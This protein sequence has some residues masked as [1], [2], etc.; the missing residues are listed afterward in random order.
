[1]MGHTPLS[2]CTGVRGLKQRDIPTQNMQQC[3]LVHRGPWKK[4]WKLIGQSRRER[5]PRLI[6]QSDT[7]SRQR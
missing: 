6:G 2:P 4:A 7:F 1:M 5:A 3:V